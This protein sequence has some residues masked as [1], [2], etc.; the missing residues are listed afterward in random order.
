MFLRRE[1]WKFAT[2]VL[3]QTENGAILISLLPVWHCGLN[4][5]FFVPRVPRS[6]FIIRIGGCALVSI[7][8][9]VLGRIYTLSSRLPYKR[10]FRI[11]YYIG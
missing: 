11:P 5:R 3:Q 2:K 8:C 7:N 6:E 4:F 1:H 10:S 9:V